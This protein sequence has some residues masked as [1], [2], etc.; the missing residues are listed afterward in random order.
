MLGLLLVGWGWQ[1]GTRRLCRPGQLLIVA[2][3]VLGLASF[4]LAALRPFADWPH[5]SVLNG[6]V[7]G[8]VLYGALVPAATSVTGLDLHCFVWGLCLGKLRRI[9]CV[10]LRRRLPRNLVVLRLSS[11]NS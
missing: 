8:D 1:L 9:V 11:K 6:G 7:I 5:P 10:S 4:A 3:L 2:P